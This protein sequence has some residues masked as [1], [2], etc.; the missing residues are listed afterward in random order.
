MFYDFYVLTLPLDADNPAGSIIC[1][2]MKSTAIK[3][4]KQLNRFIKESGAAVWAR[5]YAVTTVPEK[6][7][8]GSYF[9]YSVDY[10]GWVDTAETYAALEVVH[11]SVSDQDLAARVDRDASR[12][13]YLDPDAEGAEKE[14]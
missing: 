3:V 4:A 8:K 1:L 13:D 12:E 9:N 6:N 11:K 5:K 10:L 7:K 14:L 2:S